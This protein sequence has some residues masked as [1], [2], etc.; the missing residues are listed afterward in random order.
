MVEVQMANYTLGGLIPNV[1]EI[2]RDTDSTR[3]H[4]T[5]MQILLGAVDGFRRLLGIRP[6]ARYVGGVLADVTFPPTELELKAFSVSI[7]DRWRLGL[8]YFAASR[9]Y[10]IDVTDTVN[11]QLSQQYRQMADATFAS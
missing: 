7:E 6:E 8:V 10:E 3:Y 2:L 11:M 9:C 5:D 1:R 4:Y